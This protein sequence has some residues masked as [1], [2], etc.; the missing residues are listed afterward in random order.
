[1]K[2]YNCI[3]ITIKETNSELLQLI[4]QENSPTVRKRLLALQ[5]YVSG[6]AQSYLSIAKIVGVSQKSVSSWF[7]LYEKEGIEALLRRPQTGPA[8]GSSSVLKKSTIESVVARLDD[9]QIGF[10][11]FVELQNFVSE[12]EGK[13]VNYTT[14]YRYFRKGLGAKLK[15]VR[16]SNVK[17]DEDMS[18]V[19][20]KMRIIS[21]VDV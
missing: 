20:K 18:G 14:V 5:T 4:Q 6:V 17:K 8:V 3:S 11:S 2:T 12:K 15:A 1:M 21:S 16:P 10:Q 7:H 19:I 9:P 13:A